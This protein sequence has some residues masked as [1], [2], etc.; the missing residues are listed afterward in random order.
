MLMTQGM[1]ISRA[2]IAPWDTAPPMSITSAPRNEEEDAQD[3]SVVSQTRIS[4]GSMSMPAS[5]VEHDLARGPRRAPA[6]RPGPRPSAGVGL[7]PVPTGIGVG[8]R[9]VHVSGRRSSEYSSRWRAPLGDEAAQRSAARRRRLVDGEVEDVLG[10]VEDAAFCQFSAAG[11][12]AARAA[13][14]ACR[15]AALPTSRS[16][17]WRRRHPQHAPAPQPLRPQAAPPAARARPARA[18][19][20]GRRAGCAGRRFVHR[21]VGRRSAS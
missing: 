8:L 10:I 1:P 20:H 19:G 14:I 7:A 17:M 3:G 13:S 12:A 21:A 16:G 18:R 4:P 6:R 5:G 9:P 2:T 11:R 15:N